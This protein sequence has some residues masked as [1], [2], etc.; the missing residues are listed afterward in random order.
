[1]D[2]ER[3]ILEKDIK[4]SQKVIDKAT[5]DLEGLEV[6]YSVE[7]RIRLFRFACHDIMGEVRCRMLALFLKKGP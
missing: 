4:D 5:R 6:T 2:K 3:K 7:E 1:M